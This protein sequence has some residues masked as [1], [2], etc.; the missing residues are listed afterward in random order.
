[1]KTEK[2]VRCQICGKECDGREA[3][4]HMEETQHNRWELI[5]PKERGDEE[6]NLNASYNSEIPWRR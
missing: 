5:L 2:I 4:V 1:M 6:E 3:G